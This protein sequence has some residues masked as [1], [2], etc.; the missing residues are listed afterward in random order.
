MDSNS[1]CLASNC[2]ASTNLHSWL[3]F[4]EL[5]D[6]RPFH[7]LSP[8]LVETLKLKEKDFDS[9][10]DNSQLI[11]TA[12]NEPVKITCQ[13]VYVR[14]ILNAIMMNYFSQAKKRERLVN[15][16]TMIIHVL[17]TINYTNNYDL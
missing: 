5:R 17:K 2:L 13:Q 10:K 16:N 8:N 1:S 6:L 15:K 14:T 9:S 4:V 12:L 11:L 7:A 3:R